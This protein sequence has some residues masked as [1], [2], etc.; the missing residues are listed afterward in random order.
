MKLYDLVK[1]ILQSTPRTRSSDKRL[2]WVVWNRMGLIKMRGGLQ[3]IDAESFSSAPSSE[4][5][6]RARRK[7][8]ELHPELG[9]DPEI[10][11]ERKRKQSSKGTFIY[12]EVL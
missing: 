4:S 10:I 12:R 1:Q 3:M 5:V 8:Q 9:A 2:L 7:V 11:Q 6:T